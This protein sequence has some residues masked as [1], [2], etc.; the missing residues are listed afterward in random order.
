MSSIPLNEFMCN[1]THE[2][3]K[4]QIQLLHDNLIHSCMLSADRTIPFTK[5]D[6]KQHRNKAGWYEHASKEF[7]HALHWHRLYLQ[8]V[9]PQSGFI[10]EMRKF[11]RSIYHKKVK[12]IDSNQKRI[13][14][15]RIAKGFLEN[16]SRDFWSEISIVRRKTHITPCTVEG[17]FNNKNMSSCFFLVI[18]QICITLSLLIQLN[19]QIYTKLL[20]IR[21][22]MHVIIILS[23]LMMSKM[24][25]TN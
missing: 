23:M 5:P 7:D 20:T 9:R 2:N 14:K 19:G 6:T 22:V 13:K 12:Q 3:Y 16:R 17:F 25:L 8:H 11:T 21:S 18:I 1:H 10:F 15:T 4:C 24:P